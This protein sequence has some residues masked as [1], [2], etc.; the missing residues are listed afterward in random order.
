MDATRDIGRKELVFSFTLAVTTASVEDRKRWMLVLDRLSFFLF[1]LADLLARAIPR[2]PSFV[3]VFSIIDTTVAAASL[4]PL[5]FY[6]LFLFL[7]TRTTLIAFLPSRVATFS[8]FAGIP[9]TLATNE[10]SS[11]IGTL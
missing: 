11:L 2:A 6:T 9:L 8:L 1:S 3:H 5:L 7:Y 4:L 10:I